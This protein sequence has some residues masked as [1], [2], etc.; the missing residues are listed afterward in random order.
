MQL[1]TRNKQQQ[2]QEASD[3]KDST[4]IV[5]FLNDSQ[6]RYPICIIDDVD[7]DY[8][9]QIKSGMQLDVNETLDLWIQKYI[10]C[11]INLQIKGLPDTYGLLE[12]SNIKY[13]YDWPDISITV[14]KGMTQTIEYI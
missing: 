8:G 7:V 5:V 11:Q 6:R 9:N 12:E 13:I 4:D 1:R 2:S 3:E 14:M 10:K